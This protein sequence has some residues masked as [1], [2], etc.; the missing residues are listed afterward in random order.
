MTVM[1]V[2]HYLSGLG[3]YGEVCCVWSWGA[4]IGMVTITVPLPPPT[5][6]CVLGLPFSLGFGHMAYAGW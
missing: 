6:H 3:F 2:S 4:W 1:R 5:L